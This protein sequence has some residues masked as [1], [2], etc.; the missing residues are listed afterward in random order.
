MATAT[1]TPVA[2]VNGLPPGSRFAPKFLKLL[3]LVPVDYLKAAFPRILPAIYVDDLVLR[4]AGTLRE[5]P[6]IGKA[7]EWLVHFL[8][9]VLKLKVSKDA[10]GKR[11]KSAT[12]A[13]SQAAAQ[14]VGVKMRALGIPQEKQIK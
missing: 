5:L 14:A 11:G 4:L 7:T 9:Q 12:I 3:V 6:S 13:T 8:E 10:P 1:A 2:G